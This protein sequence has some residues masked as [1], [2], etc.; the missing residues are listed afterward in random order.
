[1]LVTYFKSISINLKINMEKILD[2][3]YKYLILVD[4]QQLK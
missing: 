3:K 2:I 4:S 1:M